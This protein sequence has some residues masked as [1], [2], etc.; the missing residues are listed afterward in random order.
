MSYTLYY[1][2]H[3]VAH[4]RMVRMVRN[5]ANLNGLVAILS[6]VLFSLS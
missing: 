4:L 3:K 1:F 6:F 2:L 5:H